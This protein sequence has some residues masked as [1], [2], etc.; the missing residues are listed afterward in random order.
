MKFFLI[1]LLTHSVSWAGG[2]TVNNG[3][4][5]VVC[6]PAPML[7]QLNGFYSLDFMALFRADMPPVQVRSVAESLHRIEKLLHEKLPELAPSFSEFVGTLFNETQYF[8]PRIWEKAAYGLV[9]LKDENFVSIVPSNCLQD[10]HLMIVQAVIRQDPSAL[11]LPKNKVLYRY[12]PEVIKNLIKTNPLQLS[13]LLVH[14]WLWDFSDN[15]ERNRRINYLLHSKNLELWSREEWIS[16]LQNLGL[17]F[18]IA[19]PKN[20]QLPPNNPPPTLKPPPPADQFHKPLP[21]KINLAI[22]SPIAIFRDGLTAVLLMRQEVNLAGVF[23]SAEALGMALDRN[24]EPV[25]IVLFDITQNIT[26]DVVFQMA[27]KWP[28]IK[29]VALGPSTKKIDYLFCREPEYVSF[30]PR[31]TGIEIFM[32]SLLSVFEGQAKCL[33]N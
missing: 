8:Q 9:D 25:D 10:G 11:G 3:G 1:L 18:K 17:N 32:D 33:Q 24:T 7:N 29:F 15:V 4:D 6:Q 27:R 5:A 19:P 26:S 31:E 22:A 14:E 30:I 2:F 23:S 13:F 16:A 12:V 20:D 28:N 21:R